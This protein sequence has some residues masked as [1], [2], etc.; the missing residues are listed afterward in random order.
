MRFS[1]FVLS[2]QILWSR[3]ELIALLTFLFSGWT[4]SVFYQS[5]QG[6]GQVRI[7]AI[8]PDAISIDAD[9]V[10][11]TVEGDGFTSASQIMWN[12][13]ALPTRLI[14]AHHLQTTVTQE[15]FIAFGGGVGNNVQISTR[16]QGNIAGCSINGNSNV[17]FLVIN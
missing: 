14:D 1:R 17:V 10:A 15:T 5:C 7:N 13:N 3:V 6:V 2:K 12:S 16:S 9:S 8:S 4:C 11:L